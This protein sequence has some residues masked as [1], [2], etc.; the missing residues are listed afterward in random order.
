MMINDDNVKF[1][2]GKF[3]FKNHYICHFSSFNSFANLMQH[4][5]CRA[6]FTHSLFRNDIFY[7]LKKS[8][9]NACFVY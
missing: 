1:N 7:I 6:E 2:I 5:I 4:D 3:K 9:N 8:Q